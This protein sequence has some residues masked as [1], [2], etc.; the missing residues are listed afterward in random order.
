MT[1]DDHPFAV[2]NAGCGQP[3]DMRVGACERDS[4]ATF[5]RVDVQ[6]GNARVAQFRN[7]AI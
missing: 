1:V 7:P 3:G 4:A 6:A 5:D 2:M